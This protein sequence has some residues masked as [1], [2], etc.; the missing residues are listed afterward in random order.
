MDKKI[1]PKDV[2]FMQINDTA[3]NWWVINKREIVSVVA[4]MTANPTTRI[5]LT[6]GAVIDTFLNV[7][8]ITG[9]LSEVE[10]KIEKEDKP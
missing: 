9:L 10:H 8:F 1:E 4:P 2:L 3:K 6:T 5:V 7:G